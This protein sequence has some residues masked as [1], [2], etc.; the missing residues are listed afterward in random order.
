MTM[1]CDGGTSSPST[2]EV[3][4]TAVEK[5]TSYPRLTIIGISSDPKDAV[6][7]EA[8]PEMPPKKYEATILTMASPPVIQPTNESARSSSFSEMPPPIRTPMVM[9]NGTAISEKELMPL[10]IC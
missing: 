5:S 1:L 10:T 6:S 7:A 3:M 2:E 4:V 9:K 8:D